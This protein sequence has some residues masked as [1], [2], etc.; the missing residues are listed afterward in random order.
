MTWRKHFFRYVGFFLTLATVLWVPACGEQKQSSTT[1]EIGKTRQAII[2]GKQDNAYPA[3]GSITAGQRSFCS[4]TLIAPRVVLTA[5]HCIDAFAQTGGA[6]IEYRIDVPVDTKNYKSIFVPVDQASCKQHPQYDR[7]QVLNDIAVV[8]LTRPVFEV[9]TVPFN[10]QK[11][12]ASW[13]GR[14]LFFMGYGR[15][16]PSDT[17]PAPFKYSTKMPITGVDPNSPQGTKTNTVSYLGNNTAVCQGDSGGPAMIELNGVM[18]VAAVTSHGTSL[19]C[20]GTSYSYRTDPYVSWIQGFVDQFSTCDGATPTCGKCAT[21][22][23]NKQC[24]PKAVSAEASNCKV[25]KADTDCAN[26]GSCVQVGSGKRCA[27][28]CDTD[29]CCP[30]DHVCTTGLNNKKYCLPN[31]MEC[32][33]AS[34]TQDSDCSAGEACLSGTCGIKLPDRK[35]TLCQP[36][37]ANTDCGGDYC[38]NPEGRGGRCLQAC[39]G[40]DQCPSGFRCKEINPGFKQCI[41]N[42]GVCRGVC[43]IDN[44]CKGGLLCD[45]TDG[46]CKRDGGGDPGEPCAQDLPCKSTL[47]CTPGTEGARCYQTCGYSPGSAGSPCRADGTCDAGLQCFQNPAGGGNF[48]VEPCQGGSACQTGGSCAPF[49]NICFCQNDAACGAGRSCNLILQGLGGACTAAVAKPCPQGEECVTNPGQQ[50]ICVQNSAGN[51]GVGQ[52]CDA[53]NRC[54]QGL[55]CIPGLNICVEDC[56]QTNTCTQGGKCQSVQF[57]PNKFC[58][59]SQPADCPSGRV[60]N[61]VGQGI[62]YCAPDEKQGCQATG[63]PTGFKCVGTQCVS[64]NAEIG[65]EPTAEPAAEST[66]TPEPTAESTP[67]EPTAEGTTDGGT[68]D[69]GTANDTPANTETT[70]PGNKSCGC[71][72]SNP[73]EVPVGFLFLLLWAV[74]FAWRRR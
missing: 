3:A 69:K 60:C 27:Q 71:Q 22:D 31:K 16:S 52:A 45:T 67:A 12:D 8:I 54:K 5:A 1:E 18:H 74:G 61:V 23:A 41:A 7:Q 59:C 19:N 68:A 21:C 47:Q 37:G 48:C 6:A 50:S 38:D 34:C 63:C 17:N 51:Q 46:F 43:K 35:T 10:T 13:V 42:D 36:C 2:N 24:A 44:D 40:N 66:V 62:G 49:I 53:V 15:L 72:Q 30:A 4:G 32:P 25:C 9:P 58:T 11:M 57:I 73:S 65:P 55:L 14:E 28:A 39:D 64:E 26:G 20:S 70:N 29:D 33:P 56:T